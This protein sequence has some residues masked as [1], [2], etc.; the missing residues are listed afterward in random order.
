MKKTI[1]A[2]ALLLSIGVVGCQYSSA[3]STSDDAQSANGSD[4]QHKA[5]QAADSAW[6]QASL[7]QFAADLKVTYRMVT[8]VPEES[9]SATQPDEQCFIAE[10]DLTSSVNIPHADWAIYFSQMRPVQAVLNPQF[11]IT[12]VQGDLHKIAPTEQFTGFSAGVT[13]RIGFRG[14]LWQLSETDPMPNYYIVVD[15]LEPVVI[16]STQLSIDAETG[17]E[18]RPYVEAFTDEKRQ[19]RRTATDNLAWS[20]AEV[21]F[22]ANNA[23]VVN[24][25]AAINR[26]I[27]TP[28]SASVTSS[29]TPVDL[30][31]GI[32]VNYQQVDSAAVAAAL[33]R[34]ARLGVKQSD[35]GLS[36][37]FVK[38]SKV[39][40][41]E[42][43]IDGAYQ[44]KVAI[45]GITITAA[46]D[47]G[48]SYGLSSLAALIDTR[49]LSINTMVVD[50][51]PRYDFRGM[52]IDVAR[53]FHSKQLIFDLIDQMAAYR[54]NKLHL[55]MA[56]DEAW[57]LEID[58]LPELTDIGSKRCHDLTES[59]CLIPQLGSGPFADASVNGFYSKADYIDILQYASARQVEV[60]PSMDMPGHSRAAIKSMDAR[61]RK[62]M[63]SGENN[64]ANEYLLTDANDTTVYSSVQYYNDNT[65][66]VCLESTY[67]FVDKVI[68]EIAK[69]HQQAGHPLKRYH[70]GADETAGAWKQSPQCV[71]FVA[72][73]DKGV[74]SIDDLGAYFIERVANMVSAKGI[75][76][77]GWSDGMSHTNADNMPAK[78]QTNI[79]DVISHHG[80]QR[81]HSQANLG[82]DTVLSNPEVLYFDFPYEADPKEHGYY[83]ATRALN[84]QK[85]FSFMPDNLPANA[86]QWNDI[87][88]NPFTADD[89][90]KKDEQGKVTSAPLQQGKGFSGIQ[91]QIWSETIR[92]DEVAEYMMFPRLLMLAEKAWHKAKWEVPYQYQGAVYH[93]NSGYFTADMRKQQQQQWNDIA[94]TLGH[95]ELAKLDVANIE[96][97][98]PTVGAKIEAGLLYANIAF[99][100]LKIE[101]RQLSEESDNNAAETASWLE[102]QAPVKVS[103]NIEIRA[104][105]ASGKR[106]GRSLFL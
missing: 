45:D 54:L 103:G 27:P 42:Q 52:H 11:S 37:A 18:V 6:T 76:P 21:L 81:A 2:S 93:Q 75:E 79:W 82:W 13:Q 71:D 9:C 12:R 95:K 87:E 20:R 67:H 5:N 56:D 68:D 55:H 64:A 58:G 7:K 83:W 57:R 74:K 39:T 94:N 47:S 90:V 69:L 26:I 88:N 36:L 80:Y 23:L 65:L 105:S 49:E 10:I 104:I 53:N 61:Y 19:Y 28:L 62:F 34:L 99:P 44:L 16:A 70:I 63:A 86:E 17:M 46:T 101:Y 92:S 29:N 66:N 22:E 106:K 30:S 96:Y 33:S 35:T 77:A 51:A 38:N 14:E 73:N 85:L 98:V 4:L 25:E 97:R 60:I 24:R 8:N 48:F 3:P 50:D 43:G 40:A 100:G 41:D 59:T 102:Y 1:L 31:Q 15:G 84:S 91:G 72:N 78:S 32:E 89:S